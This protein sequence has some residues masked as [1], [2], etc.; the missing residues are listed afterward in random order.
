MDIG[1]QRM[2]NQRLWGP[3][4]AGI[5]DAVR[6]LGAVQAQ[7]FPYARWSVAQRAGDGPESLVDKAFAEGAI[8]RTH[9]LRPTWHFVAAQDIRWMLELTGPRVQAASALQY[10]REGLT[11]FDRPTALFVEALRGGKQLDR[12]GMRAVLEEAGMAP[13]PFQLGLIIMH[14]ELDAVLCSGAIQGK[15]QTYALLEERAPNALRLSREE[16]LVELVR[17][18]FTTHGPATLKDFA[19]WSGLTQADGRKGL[20][21]L[22]FSSFVHEGR[23]YWGPPA[24]SQADG[25]P[26]VDL[27]Q[28]YDE[29]G[30]GY[31]ESRDAILPTGAP[32][33]GPAY[34]HSILLNGRL[35]GHWKRTVKGKA[36]SFDTKLLRP[37]KKAEAKAL[38][39]AQERYRRFVSG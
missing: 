26:R 8:L 28:I 35:T 13:T 16:A 9:V 22:D 14:A 2:V 38:E 36:V 12:K 39:E 27:V 34:Y 10:R 24:P 23:T 6:G 29:I 7:E 37:L 33:W 18:Y 5:V 25:R 15:Q 3:P 1:E 19:W 31:T 4:F 17:R 20:A 30:V 32:L 21:A 11:D